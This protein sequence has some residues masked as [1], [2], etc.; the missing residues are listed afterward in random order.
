[1]GGGATTLASSRG[2][3]DLQAATTGK[4]RIN[5]LT[6]TLGVKTAPP[7]NS[8]ATKPKIFKVF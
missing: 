3:T 7:L 4:V 5:I 8:K 6:A 2:T 1:M